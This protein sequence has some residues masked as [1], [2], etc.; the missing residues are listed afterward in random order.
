M[1]PQSNDSFTVHHSGVY[2]NLPTFPA[3]AGLTAIVPGATGISGWNTIRSLLD[4]PTRWF[5]IYAISRSPPSQELL[6]P[7]SS[8]QQSRI[9]HLPVDFSGSPEEI[10]SSLRVIREL[11]PYI[12]FYAYIQPKTEDHETVWSNVEKLAEANV[13]LLSSF[14]QALEIA[15]VAPKRILLQTGGKNYGLQLGRGP[16]PCVESDP[17]PRHLG[18][19]FYYP[20]E[21]SLFD[22]C[23]RHPQTSWNVIRPFGVM[24]SAV[25]AQM[26]GLYLFCVYAAVQA[27][28]KEP[29]YFPGDWNTWQ[30]PTPMSTAR[31]T[32]YLSEWAV[33]NDSCENQAYNSLDSNSMTNERFWAE[34]ARWYGNEKGAVGPLEDP[35][36]YEKT[37]LKGGKDCP[38]GYGPPLV[39]RSSF[40]MLDWAQK[41]CNKNAWKEMMKAG[42]ITSDPFAEDVLKEN[43]QLLDIFFTITVTASMNKAQLQGWTGFADTL[44]AAFE[45]VQEMVGM[46]LLP[47]VVADAARPLV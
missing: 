27:H 32:G 16:Q 5:K 43:F 15:E 29:L 41:E 20:Q 21:D 36:K 9:H 37:E 39:A 12:F 40:K 23:K 42:S 44:E 11:N 28:K 6:D 7:L 33:L 14:L 4:S 13:R 47:P 24:G 35:S 2:R 1:I 25:K 45:S 31:L 26:S 46:G 38:L 17:Q 3:V 19:N 34:L 30:G 10:A 18:T 22:Y 8:E